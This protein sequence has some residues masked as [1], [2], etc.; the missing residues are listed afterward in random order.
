M[1][2]STQRK[3]YYAYAIAGILAG[4]SWGCQGA[5]QLGYNPNTGTPGARMKAGN[6]DIILNTNGSFVA[7]NVKAHRDGFAKGSFEADMVS[8][9]PDVTPYWN[10]LSQQGQVYGQQQLNFGNSVLPAY[11]QAAA[12]ILQQIPPIIQAATPLLGPYLNSLGAAKLAAASR[13]SIAQSLADLVRNGGTTATQLDAVFGHLDPELLNQ[14]K[15]LLGGQSI[16]PPISQTFPSRAV[17]APT[18]VGD[19]PL[20]PS[21][22]PERPKTTRAAIL[23]PEDIGGFDRKS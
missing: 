8:V 6:V 9:Q 3:W 20:T 18:F 23:Q 5:P 12:L 17:P 21:E 13:P 15:A 14:V 19:S 2:Q 16:L 4:H 22:L 11:G 1:R 7:S 10:G